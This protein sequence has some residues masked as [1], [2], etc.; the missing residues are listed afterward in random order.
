MKAGIERKTQVL[1]RRAFD[2]W[3][4]VKQGEGLQ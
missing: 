1:T 4:M 2:K 3:L